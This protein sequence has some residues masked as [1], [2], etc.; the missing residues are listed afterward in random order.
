MSIEAL[1]TNLGNV[2]G[3][4]TQ[5]RR[6]FEQPQWYLGGTAYNIRIR[7]ETVA[8]FGN[9][10]RFDNILD[11]GCGD[12]SLSLP[13]LNGANR[14][15]FLDR[16]QAMLSIARSRV[17]AS[18]SANVRSINADFMEAELG[19]HN[20]DLVIA[21]G[22]LAYVERR[23]AFVERIKALLRPGGSLIIECTDVSHFISRLILTYHA[24]RRS[25]KST[26]LRTV[27]GSSSEL[28][29][30][31]EGVGFERCRPYRYSLPLPVI[32]KLM[33][34]NLSYRAIRL[35]FGT[36]THSRN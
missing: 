7:A 11:I 16:S 25:L 32:R 17:P 18:F 21:V 36:A 8:G 22:V 3:N 10:A 24:L 29:A 35:I 23:R 14:L 2:A 15:T 20:F 12:G 34:Q 1:S 31:C 9:N 28:L 6:A 26:Q 33:T 4:E 30:I 5:I 13:L 27:V 19:H